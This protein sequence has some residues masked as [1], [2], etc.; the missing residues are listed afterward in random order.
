ARQREHDLDEAGRVTGSEP[1]EIDRGAFDREIHFSRHHGHQPGTN[2]SANVDSS[3]DSGSGG[4]R[5]IVTTT[6]TTTSH[7]PRAS[8]RAIHPTSIAR[9]SNG[10]AIVATRSQSS[11]SDD[12]RNGPINSGSSAS[13]LLRTGWARAKRTIATRSP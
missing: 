4:D 12:V 7:S 10:V 8:C 3:R 13:T 1:P 11:P 5:T 9:S 6:R 2:R